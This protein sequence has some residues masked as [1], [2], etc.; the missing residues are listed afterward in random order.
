MATMLRLGPDDH[1]R[2]MT[3]DEFE[4]ADYEEGYRYEII[5]GRLYA[6]PQANQPHD[7]VEQHVCHPLW[8]YSQVRP[9]IINYVTNKARVFVPGAKRITVPEPDVAAYRDFPLKRRRDLHWRDVSPILVAEVLGGED[10]YKDLVRNVDLYLRVPSVE[11]YWLFDIRNDPAEPLLR[12]H[13][14][15][16]DRWDIR[17]FDSSAVYRTELLPGFS[18]PVRPE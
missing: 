3:L 16:Q 9:E 11:E 13:R 14:R 18:L 8:R 17:E 6:S 1:G 2:P 12:V 5:E 15:V 7:W 4:A 10:D